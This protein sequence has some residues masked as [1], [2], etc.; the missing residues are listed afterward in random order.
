M[1]VYLTN[2]CG[3][4]DPL[5]VSPNS[6]NATLGRRSGGM[7]YHCIGAPVYPAA[8]WGRAGNCRWGGF[9]R[10]GEVDERGGILGRGEAAGGVETFGR[11]GVLGW[12][13]SI[14][15]HCAGTNGSG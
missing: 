5:F 3:K 6:G 2:S 9:A 8:G 7:F 14:A 15:G 10:R 4:I 13:V 12:D 11:G 1:D